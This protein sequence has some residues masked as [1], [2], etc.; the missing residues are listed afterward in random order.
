MDVK[1]YEQPEGF[2]ISVE[3]AGTCTEIVKKLLLEFAAIS[4]LPGLIDDKTLPFKPT[5]EGKKE[6]PCSLPGYIASFLKA[7]DVKYKADSL[8][9]AFDF[10]SIDDVIANSPCVANKIFEILLIAKVK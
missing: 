1:I 9:R 5:A 3:D 4:N 6:L 2:L 8:A 10:N 7:P